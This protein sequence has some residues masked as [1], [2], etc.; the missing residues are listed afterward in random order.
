M[1]YTT[2]SRPLTTVQKCVVLALAAGSTI[3]AAAEANGIQRITIYRWMKTRKEFSAALHRARAEFVLASRDKL[4]HLSNRALDTLLTVLDNPKSSP[5]VLLRTSVFTLQ[6]LR[7][8]RRPRNRLSHPPWTQPNVSKCYTIRR[9]TRMLHPP[10]AIPLPPHPLTAAKLD[11]D[12][13]PLPLPSLK[14]A[15]VTRNTLRFST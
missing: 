11:C 10:P 9:I 14:P 13:A 3:T 5:A 1:E 2:D 7:N 12:P 6:R 8:P 4:Y 15:T